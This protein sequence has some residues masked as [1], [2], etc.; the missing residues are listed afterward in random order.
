MRRRGLPGSPGHTALR[1]SQAAQ[2]ELPSHHALAQVVLRRLAVLPQQAGIADV[3]PLLRPVSEE[4]SWTAGLPAGAVLPPAVGQVVVSALSA[5][6]GTLVERGVVPSAEVLAGLVPQLV[7]AATARAYG[8][9]TL[10]ALMTAHYRAFRNRRSL[11]LLDL[12]RQVRIEELPWVRA[13]S[14]RR[15]AVTGTSDGEGALTVLR[16]LGEV[17]VQAFPGTILPNPLVRELGVLER[18]CGLGVPFV[19][20]LAADIF[21]GEFS[22]KFLTA[23]RIAGDL[24]GG[25]LYERYYGIDYEEIRDLAIA[26]TGTAPARSRRAPTSPGFARL[27]TGRVGTT[28]GSWSVAANGKVIERAQ[29][30]TTH[31]LATLVHR[32]GIAP[33]SGWDDLAR[34]SFVTVSPADRSRPPQSAPLEHHQGCRV[35]MAPDAVLPVP[36]PARGA[37]AVRRGPGRADGPAP[38][39][40][41]GPTGPRARGPGPGGRGRHLQRRRSGGRRP[42]QALP[43]MEHRRPLDAVMPPGRA[44][45]VT[46][47]RVAQRPGG[48]GRSSARPPRDQQFLCPGAD[49]W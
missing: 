28:P 26:E 34:R 33:R 35:R 18:Q 23:A 12:E 24:L 36:V 15:S 3:E 21:M 19:E 46:P 31:N 25:T 11:L 13:V 20:E 16:Q 7:A 6:L 30:L 4:E 41:R 38:Q 49:A 8:D 22:R 42:Q 1:R 2:A 40:R 48:R 10:R 43:G 39:P 5:P 37:A 45:G 14:G 29:I 27:A 47:C 9:E 17:A 32:V 44:G